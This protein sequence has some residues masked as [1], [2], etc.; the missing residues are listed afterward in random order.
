MQLDAGKKMFFTTQLVQSAGLLVQLRDMPPGWTSRWNHV[1]IPCG[2]S[3]HPVLAASL[4]GAP[5]HF[6]AD[7]DE[8]TDFE[9]TIRELQGGFGLIHSNGIP[10]LGEPSQPY[11]SK[12]WDGWKNIE[13]YL[14][15]GVDA[16]RGFSEKPDRVETGEN[17]FEEWGC[18]T[19]HGGEWFAPDPVSPE[20]AVVENGQVTNTLADVGTSSPR[21]R[22]KSGKFD[23]PSL[24]GV[25]QTAPYFHDGS[26]LT[27]EDVLANKTHLRA[28]LP[29]EKQDHEMS[30]DEMEAL[31][32]LPKTIS[33]GTPA[34]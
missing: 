29:A 14:R 16:P 28:G 11:A 25:G 22:S 17:V 5:L 1:G 21:D 33:V 6:D 30:G 20:E 8:F 31:I 7:N 4:D 19:C 26:A 9:H 34:I 32:E 15:E 12:G 23:P 3:F 13:T 18:G 10:P 27:L 2:T 24:W